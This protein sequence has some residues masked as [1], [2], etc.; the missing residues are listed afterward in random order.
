MKPFVEYWLNANEYPQKYHWNV[1]TDNEPIVAHIILNAD[2]LRASPE[3]R[4][5]RP[6]TM[7][8]TM[9]EAT[10]MYA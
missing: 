3:Y 9:A 5:P 10:I 2:F 1:M 7:T 6:G 4:K 8:S